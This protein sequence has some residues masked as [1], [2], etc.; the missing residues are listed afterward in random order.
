MGLPLLVSWTW[1]LVVLVGLPRVIRAPLPAVLM[2]LPDLGYPL[3]AS[4]VLAFGW[5]LVRAIWAIRTLRTPPPGVP[6]PSTGATTQLSLQ[7]R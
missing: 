4:A 6:A 7:P 2:G 5:G 1:A 3:V